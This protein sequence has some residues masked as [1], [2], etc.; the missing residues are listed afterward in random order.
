MKQF[1][2][3]VLLFGIIFFVVD[4]LF[5]VFLFVAPT[6]EVDKRL[7]MLIEG[8]I[9][10][11]IIVMGSS[12]GADNII[13]GQIEKQ[14]KLSSYNLS[15]PGSDIDFHE[16]ILKTLLKY[17]QKPKIIVLAIDNPSEL[18]FDKTLNFRLER[19]YPLVKY[20]YYNQVLIDK[21]GR[22]QLSRFLCLARLN[23]GNFSFTKKKMPKQNPILDCGSMPFVTENKSFKFDFDKKVNYLAKKELESKRKQFLEFGAIC[24][25]N[26]ILLI[27]SFSP[28]YRKYNSGIENRI[29][30][31]STSENK[32]FIYDT[33]D[34]RYKNLAYFYDEAHLNHNGAKIFTSELS[35][36]INLNK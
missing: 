15:Y 14:T 18:M 35:K 6:L 24:K 13:A 27:Y 10:K 36:F 21:E 32:F 4:K 12:R 8:K 2:Y 31:L 33:T 30:Q 20:N 34:T 17:N 23:R 28:N 16:F 3:K 26:N 29:R 5:L 1:I 25:E 19:L 22:T 9:N 11:D 7:E